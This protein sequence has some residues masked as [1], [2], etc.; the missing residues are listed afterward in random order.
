MD[1]F[2]YCG[3]CDEIMEK[4]T[5]YDCCSKVVCIDC[6]IKIMKLNDKCPYC[7]KSTANSLLLSY[8]CVF[9]PT[10]Y[11]SSNMTTKISHIKNIIT[12]TS[13]WKMRKTI[14]LLY[15][16]KLLKDNDCIGD[17]LLVGGNGKFVVQVVLIL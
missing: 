9:R 5:I 11:I 16:K 1:N 17:M 8:N 2:D 3:I 4:P 10:Y 6:Y 12:N 14:Q 13:I 7:R 15:H